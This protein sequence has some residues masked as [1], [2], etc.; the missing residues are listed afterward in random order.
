MSL[1]QWLSNVPLGFAYER[2]VRAISEALA[3]HLKPSV[4]PDQFSK[5]MTTRLVDPTAGKQAGEQETRAKDAL[6]ALI[7]SV[8]GLAAI[9]YE[10]SLDRPGLDELL[11]YWY[12]AGAV[13]QGNQFVPVAALTH[14]K[15]LTYAL[16]QRGR[17]KGMEWA[18]T[19]TQMVQARDWWQ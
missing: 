9:A 11:D 12:N 15:T 2:E 3:A 18:S 10:H 19:L 7:T 13:W 16:A 1:W 17:V 6:W 8:P 14:P 5:L 4:T